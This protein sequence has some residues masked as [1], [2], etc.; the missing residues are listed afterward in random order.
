MKTIIVIPARL[1]STR[2]SRKLLLAE[3]G[4]SVLQHTY[5]QASLSQLADEVVIACDHPEI[6][7]EVKRFG[8]QVMM[9]RPDHVCGTD[10]VAEAAEHFDA[11]LIV[12][13]QGDEPEI[14]P[15]AIDLLVGLLQSNPSVPVATLAA[16]IRKREDLDNPACVKVVFDVSGR[17]LYFSRSPIPHPR[18]WEAGLLDGSSELFAG[19]E[20]GGQVSGENQP[21]AAAFWQHIGLY[22]YRRDF[23]MNISSIP[24]T[25]IEKIESLEQLRFLYAGHTMLVGK[26]EHSA[27]GIDTPEDYAAFVSRQKK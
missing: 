22:G 23:L 2:L 19:A 16:P 25:A 24:A 11:N 12:N 8:G 13:V 15:A 26:V 10:R 7:A 21:I 14:D 17:A 9:T 27:A 4:K 3:T 20:Q 1:A 5:E 6:E 18:N